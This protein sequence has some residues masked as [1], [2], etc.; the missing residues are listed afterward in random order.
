M[1]QRFRKL[2]YHLFPSPFAIAVLLTVLV[3]GLALIFTQRP[4]NAVSSYPIKLLEYW[5]TGFWELLAFTMQMALILIL[6][7][8]LAL[9]PLFNR[10]INLLTR[11]CHTTATAAMIV[12]LI[13]ILL[14]FFNWGLCL[15]FGAI[16]ARKVAERSQELG[17]PLN[18]P[19]IGA[20]GYAG[21]MCW[22]GGLSGSAP[23]TVSGKS[24]FLVNQIGVVG[25]EETL[26]STMNIST[27]LCLIVLIPGFLYLLGRLSP[28]RT[29]KLKSQS[30]KSQK[31]TTEAVGAEKLDHARFPAIGLGLLICF[32]AFRQAWNTPSGSGLGFIDLN[33]INFLLFGLGLMMHC[34]FSNF[35]TAIQKAIGGASGILIQFPLYAGIMG[36]MK[37]SGL[38]AEISYAFVAISN[39]TTLPIFTFIS[40]GLVNV[41][42]PSGGGQWAVQ[43]P[44]VTEAAEA[45]GVSIPKIIMALSYG[46]QLT[47]MLQPFWALP[48]LGI[49]QL[50]AKDILP[51][52]VLVMMLGM[53]IFIS[54]LLIF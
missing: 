22:H 54:N 6:G 51:Y 20:A 17:Q 47:N 19:L 53:L 48:L 8:A 45:L 52:S 36:I 9:T 44:I 11:Y 28:H 15:V 14:S 12:G 41:F 38:G 27:S 31:L 7:H 37:Y 34:S 10:L 50:K 35:L 40:A 49:T 43:G 16:F 1:S 25:I 24:H 46:D 4:E 18:Y 30:K 26:L 29:F 32:I 33:Y 3:Y 21:M 2:F 23:L 13:T 42:V 5:Q 39:Q